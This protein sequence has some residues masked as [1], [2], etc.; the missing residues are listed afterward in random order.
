MAM[1]PAVLLFDELTSALDPELV[2]EVLKVMKEL[3]QEGM[4]MVVVAHEM[5]FAREAADK[6]VFIDRGVNM[7]IRIHFLHTITFIPSFFLTENALE[8]S[9]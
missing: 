9:L 8:E 7:D 1:E 2:G 6:V 4:T 3:A 5:N